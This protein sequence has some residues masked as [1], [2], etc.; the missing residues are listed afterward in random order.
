MKHIYIIGAGPGSRNALTVEAQKAV[1]GSDCI[2]AHGRLLR[3]YENSGKILLES[4]HAEKIADYVA[5]LNDGLVISVL[6]S[7]DTGFYSLAKKLT[8]LLQ[9][10]DK[11]DK[12][13][14]ISGVSSVAYFCAKLRSSWDD[15]LLFSLHGRPGSVA[16]K[17]RRNKKVI[18]LTDAVYTPSVI[19]GELCE[20]GLENVMLTAG[21]NLSY[22]DEAITSL[23]AREA[24]QRQFGALCVL[25]I[26][27]PQPEEHKFIG[28]S[29][30]IRG[31]TPMTKQEIRCISIN[32]LRLSKTDIVYDA[33]A[34][35]GSVAVEIA[36]QIPD[37]RVFALEKEPEALRLIE[38]N[39][40]KFRA[41][42]LE[43]IQG[44]A[45]EAILPLPPPDKVFIGGSGGRLTEILEAVYRKN[46]CAYV[47][48][49]AVTLETFC[50][51]VSY[52]KN[53]EAYFFEVVQVGVNSAKE[54]GSYHLLSAQNPV[55]IITAGRKE[56][57][58]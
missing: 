1:E 33:G 21:E 56:T 8:R 41:G 6:V 18:V 49:N 29:D 45:E 32:K 12:V 9:A 58:T 34:G 35:T 7:G 22:E 14:M 47:V 42:N 52:Y 13:E 28:D 2:I 3:D 20:N 54:A 39:K 23:T 4:S 26:E 46:D 11:Q 17:V 37:G 31:N 36:L 43:I 24:A 57:A 51:A 15:A 40:R 27:N 5:E 16:D 53:R 38:E 10:N 44:N 25:Q 30:F 50:E 48:I 19:A 55:F